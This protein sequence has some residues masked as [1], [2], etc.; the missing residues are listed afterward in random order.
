[1]DLMLQN[2][3]DKDKHRKLH[4]ELT[5]PFRT[6]G[7]TTFDPDEVGAPAWWHGEDEAYEETMAAMSAL[8]R[9]G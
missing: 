3:P 8:P 5:G 9:R 4:D 1:M 6:F 2:E 7:G